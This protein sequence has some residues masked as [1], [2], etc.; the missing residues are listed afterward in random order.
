MNSHWLGGWELARRCWTSQVS[1]VTRTTL[2]PS[3]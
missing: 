2:V 3:Q 1:A